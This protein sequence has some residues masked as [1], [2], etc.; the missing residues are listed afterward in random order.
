MK[1]GRPTHFD[2][3]K[4]K[5]ILQPYY[6]KG[7]S[8]NVT[9]NATRLNIKTVLKYFKNW[10]REILELNGGDFLRRAKIAKEKTLQ[11]LDC[12]IISLD[13]EEKEVNSAKY[14]ARK[15]GNIIHW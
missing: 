11:S 15:T 1:R 3:D 10:D 5:K 6:Q 12:E 7:I 14:I 9:A 2:Q 8:A 13:R 4:I